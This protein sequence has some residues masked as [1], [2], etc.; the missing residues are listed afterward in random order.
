MVW[1]S[2]EV[3]SPKMIFNHY[4]LRLRQE[5]YDKVPKVIEEKKE[6]ESSANNNLDPSKFI[7]ERCVQAVEFIFVSD[8]QEE[9]FCERCLAIASKLPHVM[10]FTVIRVTEATFALIRKGISNVL[11]YNEMHQ[12]IPMEDEVLVKYMRKWTLQSIMWGVGGSLTL[13]ER[14]NFS[15]A[16]SEHIPRHDIQLPAML[17]QVEGQAG[18]AYIL[19]DFEINIEDGEWNLWKKK[20]PTV[21]IDPQKV[22]DADVIIPTVDTLRHQEILCSWLS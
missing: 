12:E 5:D 22:T 1:F 14:G 2:E 18:V 16:I 6:E 7:R 20:V 13:K 10:E 4:L 11:E 8:V 9:S 3:I 21:E 15:R 17:D 19:I